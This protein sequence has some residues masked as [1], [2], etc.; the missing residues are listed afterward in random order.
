MLL[1]DG[2]LKLLDFGAVRD[3]GLT[4]AD[5]ELTK[6]T[7]AILK[8]GYAPIEQYQRHGSLGPWTDVYAMC[9][10]IYYCLTGEVPPDAPERLLYDEE[11][12]LEEKIPELQPEQALA[13]SHGMEL[14]ATARTASMDVL[15]EELYSRPA[16]SGQTEA[17]QDKA[18]Q[19]KSEQDKPGRPEPPKK[20]K[21]WL[22]LAAGVAAVAAL[23]LC[24]TLLVGGG[25]QQ[26]PPSAPDDA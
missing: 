10:T 13:L 19:A 9:A 15:L 12:R 18:A 16:K 25:K 22:L 21:S 3:V 1:P 6:S 20:K 5:K 14:R 26:T 8:Q 24:I 17:A 11:L 23:A 7:E 4:A 2:G